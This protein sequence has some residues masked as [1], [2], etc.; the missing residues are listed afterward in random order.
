[1]YDKIF[2]K[3]L[4]LILDSIM[5]CKARENNFVH[6]PRLCKYTYTIG[7]ENVITPRLVSVQLLVFFLSFVTFK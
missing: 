2:L 4:K 6:L 5:C 3:N 1:M 7:S